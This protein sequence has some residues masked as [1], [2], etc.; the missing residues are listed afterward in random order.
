MDVHIHIMKKIKPLILFFAILLNSCVKNADKIK[1]EQNYSY[2]NF[3]FPMHFVPFQDN[4]RPDDVVNLEIRNQCDPLM[5]VKHK[6]GS[7]GLGKRL[8]EWFKSEPSRL[9]H[10]A[11]IREIIYAVAHEMGA[12]DMAA[13]LLFRKAILESSGNEG[14][15]HLLHGDLAAAEKGER[16]AIELT[17][18]KLA[19]ARIPVFIIENGELKQPIGISGNPITHGAWPIGRGLYGMVTPYYVPK[20]L[21]KDTPPWAICD[22]IT[23]TIVAIWSVRRGLEKCRTNKMRAAYRWLSAGTCKIR[24]EKKEKIFERL[25]RGKI[26]GLSLKKI[27]PESVVDFGDRWQISLDDRG[28]PTKENEKNVSTLTELIRNRLPENGVLYGSI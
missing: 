20:Y 15:L 16:Y 27:N 26:R 10:Q 12:D 8:P 13:E 1:I 28:F 5:L 14:A 23:A 21:G 17:S 18:E 7:P 22:P 2:G 25:A 4:L 3:L 24:S 9:D 19:K 11:Q 6:D